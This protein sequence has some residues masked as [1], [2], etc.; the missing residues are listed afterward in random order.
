[1]VNSTTL[2]DLID[3]METSANEIGDLILSVRKPSSVTCPNE[4]LHEQK[5]K[6]ATSKILISEQCL[7]V[8]K[9][10]TIG[11]QLTNFSQEY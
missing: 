10:K 7:L 11:H 2:P 4:Y 3:L 5:T 8:F 6:N 1:L 9:L